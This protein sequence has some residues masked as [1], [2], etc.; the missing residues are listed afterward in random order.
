MYKQ[1]VSGEVQP[2]AGHLLHS[3]ALSVANRRSLHKLH[4]FIHLQVVLVDDVEDWDDR[5]K[6]MLLALLPDEVE[7]SQFISPQELPQ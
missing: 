5:R 4:V 3:H 2:A 7:G 1:S 6:P